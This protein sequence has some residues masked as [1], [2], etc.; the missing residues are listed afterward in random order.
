MATPR[1]RNLIRLNVVPIIKYRKTLPVA[2]KLEGFPSKIVMMTMTIELRMTDFRIGS[3]A[4][5]LSKKR[6]NK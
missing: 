6:S 3:F 2:E 1:A 5:I 4:G